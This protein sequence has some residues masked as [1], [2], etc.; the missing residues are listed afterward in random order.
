MFTKKDFN[1]SVTNKNGEF[2]RVS[3]LNKM[4]KCGAIVINRKNSKSTKLRQ[5]Q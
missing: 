1:L 5:E 2:V 3:E 4:I